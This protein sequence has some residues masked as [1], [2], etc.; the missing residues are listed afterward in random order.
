MTHVAWIAIAVNKLSVPA[1]FCGEPPSRAVGPDL[2]A[3][4]RP[5][6]RKPDLKPSDTRSTLARALAPEDVRLGDFVAL[7]DEIFELPSYWWCVDSSLHPRD[8]LVRI[9]MIPTQENVPLKVKSV[10]L[11]FVLAKNP[12]GDKRTLDLRRCRLARLDRTYAASAWSAYKQQ[13][14]S[15]KKRSR[16]G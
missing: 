3:S 12:A 13:L 9:R 5:N 11:P 2:M 6:A 7:L 16:W 1:R 10:C 4:S 8:Q 14:R 15:K